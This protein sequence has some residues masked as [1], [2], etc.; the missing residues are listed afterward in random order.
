MDTGEF[1]EI[2]GYSTAQQVRDALSRV[3]V[4]INAKDENGVTALMQS[5][6]NKENPEVINILIQAGADVNAKA[7]DG[8]TALMQAAR[9]NNLEFIKIL[10]K[11]GADINVGMIMAKQR[12]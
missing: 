9:N 7:C 4:D 6:G 10:L 1:L 2:C 3:D 5:I 12:F 11:A 8:N